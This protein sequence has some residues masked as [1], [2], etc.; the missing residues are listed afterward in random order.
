[1]LT[2]HGKIIPEAKLDFMEFLESAVMKGLLLETQE[3]KKFS[4]EQTDPHPHYS[5]VCQVRKDC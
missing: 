2:L 5:P 4:K 1:M 3:Q